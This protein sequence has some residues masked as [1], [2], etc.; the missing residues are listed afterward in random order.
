MTRRSVF[1]GW[2]VVAAFSVST[3]V[4]TGVRHAV[5]PFLKPIVADLGLDPLPSFTDST[6]DGGKPTADRSLWLVSPAAHHFV[7]SSLASQPGL[8]R[9]A[10]EPVVQIHPDDAAERGIRD[11]DWVIVENG[12]GWFR[13]K[14]AVTEAVRRGVAASPK[15]RWGKL[16]G[17]RNVNW[18][19][20]DALGDMNGQSTFHTNRVW[21]RREGR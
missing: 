11:G 9:N 12:R 3:F 19:T 10:G 20:S 21:V 6:D 17:G 1:Y 18:T 15:G 2:W 16:S 4:S 13:V 5:G 8:L 14:A 7:S